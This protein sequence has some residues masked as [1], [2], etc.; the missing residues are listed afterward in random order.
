MILCRRVS[1]I[2]S[3]IRLG[4]Q[5][6]AAPV[7]VLHDEL[8]VQSF[9]SLNIFSSQRKAYPFTASLV[10]LPVGGKCDAR[11]VLVCC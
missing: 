4:P 3:I 10:R 2:N 6:F 9:V 1:L 8:R 5:S 11:A 7:T